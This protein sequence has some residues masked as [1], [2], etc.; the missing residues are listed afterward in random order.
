MK[1]SARELLAAL[2]EVVAVSPEEYL[3]D[4]VR[5]HYCL[6]GERRRHADEC[7]WVEAAVLVTGDALPRRQL[8]GEDP[9]DVEA[10]LEDAEEGEGYRAATASAAEDARRVLAEYLGTAEGLDVSRVPSDDEILEDP[11]DPPEPFDP[12]E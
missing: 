4:G 5:C 2:A 12:D 11:L 6:A 1:T 8:V 10:R 7:P 9:E 3:P